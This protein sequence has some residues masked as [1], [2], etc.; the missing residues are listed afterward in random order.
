MLKKELSRVKKPNR[1]FQFS[2]RIWFPHRWVIKRHLY[3]EVEVIPTIIADSPISSTTA[4]Q[5]PG[6]PDEVPV[7]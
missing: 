1:V 6:T 5:H 2:C 7:T 3:G 4:D